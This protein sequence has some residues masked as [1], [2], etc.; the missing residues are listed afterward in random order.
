MDKQIRRLRATP[1][2]MVATRNVGALEHDPHS[3]YKFNRMWA[4]IWFT[5]MVVIPF[6]PT[7]YAHSVS[8][9]IIQEISLWANFATH[10]GAMSAALAAQ[11]TAD[12][13]ADTN[14]AVDTVLEAV[15]SQ[16]PTA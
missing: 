10:F 2:V 8:A 5:T 6:I 11:G 13:V 16:D 1:L 12:T 7:L 3:Q 15:T 4:L 9:L 14:E